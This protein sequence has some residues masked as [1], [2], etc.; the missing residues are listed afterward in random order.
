MHVVGLRT[1]RMAVYIFGGTTIASIAM[2]PQTQ[3]VMYLS[4]A[5]H[6]N[7]PHLY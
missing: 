2:L 7:G 1:L 5:A 4:T 3:K 6:A